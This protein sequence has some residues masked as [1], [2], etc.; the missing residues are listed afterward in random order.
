MGMAG[1]HDIVFDVLHVPSPLERRIQRK[2][3]LIRSIHCGQNPHVGRNADRLPLIL[4]YYSGNVIINHPILAFAPFLRRISAVLGLPIQ[5]LEQFPEYG[6]RV[7]PIDFLYHQ[8]NLLVRAPMG[9]LKHVGKRPRHKVVCQPISTQDGQNLPHKI[10]ICIVRMKYH[11][12]NTVRIIT[13]LL[14]YLIALSHTRN[15][16]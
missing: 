1:P 10:R 2:Y 13:I 12:Y 3:I 6:R 7:P 5:Q 8:I 11:S 14:P 15:P 4:I 9:L 16:I